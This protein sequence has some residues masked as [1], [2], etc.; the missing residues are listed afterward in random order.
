MK[1]KEKRK[2]KEFIYSL[3]T[4]SVRGELQQLSYKDDP[5]PLTAAATYI[6][7]V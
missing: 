7:H 1:Q 5:P 4:M 3:N 2:T 6:S